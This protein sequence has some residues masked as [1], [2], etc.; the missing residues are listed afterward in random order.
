MPPTPS[1]I[2]DMSVYIFSH[3]RTKEELPD[4]LLV[5]DA[6]LAVDPIMRWKDHECHLHNNWAQS[7]QKCVCIVQDD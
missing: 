4:Y 3:H 2:N 1:D 7:V 5:A 6:S